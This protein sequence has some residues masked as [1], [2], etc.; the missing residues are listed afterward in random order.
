[1]VEQSHMSQSKK[2]QH[3]TLMLATHGLRDLEYVI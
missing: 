2:K 3:L 1:M